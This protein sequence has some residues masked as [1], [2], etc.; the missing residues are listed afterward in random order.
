LGLIFKCPNCH[1][2][3][4]LAKKPND[5]HVIQNKVVNNFI[6]LKQKIKII[7]KRIW[8]ISI[9][10][11]ILILFI[12]FV[13]NSIDKEIKKTKSAEEVK[14]RQRQERELKKIVYKEL[15]EFYENL[16]I[17]AENLS[18]EDYEKHESLLID[19]LRAHCEV[20]AAKHKVPLDTAV[21][22]I[23]E[24]P[25]DY[26]SANKKL[27]RMTE[28][29]KQMPTNNKQTIFADVVMAEDICTA[30]DEDDEILESYK[31]QIA[32]KYNITRK[33]LDEIC[34]EAFIRSW[35]IPSNP[36]DED[37]PSRAESSTKDK[38][39][40]DPVFER[41]LIS[42]AKSLVREHLMA[43]ATAKFPFSTSTYVSRFDDHGTWCVMG[44]VDAQNVFGALLRSEYTV[45]LRGHGAVQNFDLIYLQIGDQPVVGRN[46]LIDLFEKLDALEKKEKEKDKLLDSKKNHLREKFEQHL[47]VN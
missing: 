47:K 24:I 16:K 42:H 27:G 45:Y 40:I 7:P 21:Q 20:V 13:S 23:R 12:R 3:C 36:F 2:N 22:M 29:V 33:Q 6:T 17:S 44:Q 43:P 19:K 25:S 39:K 11:I 38:K 41:D 8:W 37:F 26:N 5:D 4:R 14:E 15:Y 1:G 35:P 28:V 34:S 10:I 31:E 9:G 32:K 46:P 30:F 18:V